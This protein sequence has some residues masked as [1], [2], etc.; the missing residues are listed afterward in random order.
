MVD[1]VNKRRCQHPVSFYLGARL[2]IY[3]ILRRGR[4][5]GPPFLLKFEY[6]NEV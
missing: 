5:S 1:V 2:V 4:K 3:L 6:E